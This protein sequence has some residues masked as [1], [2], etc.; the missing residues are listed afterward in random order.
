MVVWCLSNRKLTT[1]WPVCLEVRQ[2][3]LTVANFRNFQIVYTCRI[4]VFWLRAHWISLP[5]WVTTTNRCLQTVH[6]T[7]GTPKAGRDGTWYLGSYR[8][9]RIS[10]WIGTKQPSDCQPRIIILYS[11]RYLNKIQRVVLCL[12]PDLTHGSDAQSTQSTS[13]HAY[14]LT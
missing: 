8:E 13:K 7:E 10:L 5:R 4:S 2:T 6:L 12:T 3:R 9:L 14:L 1:Q 11:N